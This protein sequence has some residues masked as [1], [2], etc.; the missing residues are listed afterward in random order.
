MSPVEVARRC[1][2]GDGVR[3]PW[4][5]AER[6]EAA[7]RLACTAFGVRREELKAAT[8]SKAHIAFARQTAMYLAHVVGELSLTEV[9]RGFA[10][11]RTTVSH[12]CHLI[13]DRRDDPDF[14]ARL[15]RM[16]ATLS[17]MLGDCETA[18]A[19]LERKQFAGA[20]ERKGAA[21]FA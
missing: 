3:T 10:R 18:P 8:R 12:A 5:V 20:L 7:C 21:L 13:E 16:E 4:D 14:D 19:P 2:R 6:V 17:L 11:D 15:E 1:G 9:A